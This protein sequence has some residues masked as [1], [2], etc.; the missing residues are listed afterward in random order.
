MLTGG[1]RRVVALV[2]AVAA[3]WAFA[4]TAAEA[5]WLKAESA[6]F[7]VYSDG[8]EKTLR[9]YVQKLETFDTLLRLLH[10]LPPDEAPPRKLPIY[11]VRSVSQL[12][13]VQPALGDST[14]GVYMASSEDI[15]ALAIRSRS[16]DDALMHEYVHH[17]ML[18]NFPYAYPAWLVEGYAE[19]YMT[20]DANAEHVTW[21]EFNENRGHWLMSGR[22]IPL[23]E[24]LVKTGGDMKRD[25]AV[26][27][28]Y[29][30]SW[31]VTHYFL[32]DDE[33]R[34]QLDAYLREVG[35]GADS[36]TAMETA[37]GQKIDALD[38]TL[39]AYMN[40]KLGY[41]RVS[42]SRFPT[43]AVT[44]TQ[45]PA[46]AV[47]LLLLNQRLKVA[48][49]DRE[50]TLKLARQAAAK[51]PGD[52][53]ARLML[54]HGELH[55][56]DRAAGVAALRDLLADHSDHVEAMQFLAGELLRD[57]GE[58]KGDEKALRAE[59]NALLVRAYKL[60]PDDFRTLELAARLREGQPGYPNDNDMQLWLSA[61]NLAPQLGTTRMGTARAMMHR[62]EFKEAILLLGPMANSPHGGAWADH[63]R[64]LIDR[65]KAGQGPGAPFKD[66]ETEAAED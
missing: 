51:H 40:G 32:S 61:Y 24:L 62:G 53:T 42:A 10:G 43:A 59:A 9:G 19:F 52:P 15:F 11:L 13:F 16:E 7:I 39:K 38:K 1:M 55:F 34:K 47:D 2:A 36:I 56:G 48:G 45:L 49:T 35:A 54:G 44:V 60:D 3:V 30:Q 6:R 58:G 4:A 27:M 66:E 28:Y 31:L 25:T 21:G 65:A 17:F 14:A 23:R 46:S 63:A 18:Q 5:R 26:A 29:A 20:M 41:K 33:R 37:T 22:W 12:Q 8:D 57:L 64:T 50:K